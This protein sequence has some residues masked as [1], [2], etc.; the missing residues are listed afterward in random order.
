MQVKAWRNGKAGTATTYGLKVGHLNRE[1]FFDHA[2]AGIEVELDGEF[3]DFELS[4]GF[5]HLC[6]EIRDKRRPLIKDWLRRHRT[7]PWPKGEPPSA[8]LIPLGGNRFRLVR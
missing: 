6:P 1:E 2:W 3:H 7:L 4:R 8:E 5:W